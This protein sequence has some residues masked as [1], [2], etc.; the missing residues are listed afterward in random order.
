MLIRA[1][2]LVFF[3]VSLWSLCCYR[4]LN[5]KLLY[6]INKKIFFFVGCGREGLSFYKQFFGDISGISMAEAPRAINVLH[7]VSA[8]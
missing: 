4:I 1:G 3:V 7:M 8:F 2:C 5:L 6:K